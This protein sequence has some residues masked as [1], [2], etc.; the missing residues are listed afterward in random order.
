MDAR[1]DFK[2]AFSR[3]RITDRGKHFNLRK[4]HVIITMMRSVTVS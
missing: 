3:K 2:M 1:G 4:Q